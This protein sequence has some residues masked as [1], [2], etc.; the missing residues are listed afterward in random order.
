MAGYL[1][2]QCTFWDELRPRRTIWSWSK[3]W[4]SLYL[5]AKRTW[6]TRYV[7]YEPGDWLRPYEYVLIRMSYKDSFDVKQQNSHSLS[8]YVSLALIFSLGLFTD[9][10][11]TYHPSV[12]SEIAR[13]RNWKLAVRHHHTHSSTISIHSDGDST[14]QA[15]SA[16]VMTVEWSS[17]TQS[18][19]QPQRH[20]HQHQLSGMV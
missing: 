3:I 13:C 8:C 15:H 20:Q 4:G 19:P 18:Q 1:A 7:W 2:L 5:G 14:A 16:Y 6:G 12:Q 10:D 9:H 17:T 11:I